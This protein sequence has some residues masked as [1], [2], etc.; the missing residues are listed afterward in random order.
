MIATTI[1]GRALSLFITDA[2]SG[3]VNINKAIITNSNDTSTNKKAIRK[4]YFGALWKNDMNINNEYGKPI[5]IN[6]VIS[7]TVR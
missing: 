3:S 5:V 1:F 7:L 4:S 6:I 2:F